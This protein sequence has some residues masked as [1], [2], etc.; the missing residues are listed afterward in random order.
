M[1]RCVIIVVLLICGCE[2][3]PDPVVHYLALKAEMEKE[4]AEA[5]KCRSQMRKFRESQEFWEEQGNAKN[6]NKAGAFYEQE[7]SDWIKHDT[8][9][10]RLKV[11][12][13]KLSGISE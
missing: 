5:E 12:I 10:I 3:G 9:K 11:K 2:K 7:S 6:A 13:S 4:S 8:Q 1:A